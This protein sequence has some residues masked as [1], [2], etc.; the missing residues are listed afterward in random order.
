[1]PRNSSLSTS[2]LALTT[3]LKRDDDSSSDIRIKRDLAGENIAV[4]DIIIVRMHDEKQEYRVTQVL[5]DS[6]VA[7]PKSSKRKFT[8]T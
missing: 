3:A 5:D 7:R 1:M 6:V 2:F 8:K 4:G